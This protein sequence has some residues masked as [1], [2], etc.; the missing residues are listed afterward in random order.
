MELVHINDFPAVERAAKYLVCSSSGAITGR[1]GAT[2]DP[3]WIKVG[4]SGYDILFAHPLMTLDRG[5]A[6]GEVEVAVLGLTGKE[7]GAAAL[8]DASASLQG[9]TLRISTVLKVLGVL[10]IIILSIMYAISITY[11][12]QARLLAIFL[13]GIGDKAV[14][15]RF[16]IWVQGHKFTGRDCNLTFVDEVLKVDLQTLWVQ[17]NI[18]S[19]VDEIDVEVKLLEI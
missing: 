5:S 17:N 8:I 14:D 16:E 4:V 13:S 10:G 11:A 2:S 6:D 15:D 3:F 12:N 9:G 1:M 7:V 18:A 19:E